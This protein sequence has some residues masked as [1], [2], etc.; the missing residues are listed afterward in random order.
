MHRKIQRDFPLTSFN[1]FGIAV[2]ARRFVGVESIDEL[3]ELRERPE[4][5]DGRR[6][7]LG[8]GSNI[9]FTSDFDGLVVHVATRGHEYL[10]DDGHHHL[11]AVEAGESWD[12][13][14]RDS[15]RAG[16]PGLENLAWIPGTV[17]AAPVQ[18]IGAYGLEL[19]ERLAAVEVMDAASG[20]MS[21]IDT[22]DAGFGY[23]DS[24]FKHGLRERA[25]ITRVVFRLP[26]A[27]QPRLTYAELVKRL[28]SVS[29]P[30]PEQIADAV[31][32]IRREK[33]PDPAVAGNA[34]SFFKNPTIDADTYEALASRHPDI[35]AHPVDGGYKLAAAWLIDR[36]GWR[37]RAL[38][39]S[40]AAVHDR[41]ALV[42][43]NRGG[44]SGAEVLALAT[45]IRED[46]AERFGIELQPE[47]LI[48]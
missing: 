36:C 16:W 10:G 21:R 40:K 32:A 31:T 1:T 30:D 14:V 44:A 24:V 7:I 27:W 15:L 11:V 38:D 26:L 48:V 6:L 33:L 4:W 2:R 18:N 28:A 9:L 42:L 13:F 23:R 12:G 47:P 8:G 19:A 20:A 41:H 25:I 22:A 46:V 5:N 29:S 17:G 35:V 43:V 3:R 34:G 39:G 37:G 45:A